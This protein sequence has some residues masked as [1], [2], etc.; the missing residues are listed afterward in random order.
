MLLDMDATRRRLGFL[1]DDPH[2]SLTV[3]A[4]GDW[5]RHITLERDEDFSD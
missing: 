3:L 4:E 2:V 1:R 5:Y